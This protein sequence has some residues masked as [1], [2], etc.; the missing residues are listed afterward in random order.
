MDTGL[1]LSLFFNPIFK[2]IF[3]DLSLQKAKFFFSFTS[4]TNFF[5]LLSFSSR[6]DKNI[7]L[8]Y[9]NSYVLW[10]VPC[11]IIVSWS[12]NK[13]NIYFQISGK[14]MGLNIFEILLCHHMVKTDQRNRSYWPKLRGFKKLIMK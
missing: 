6:T 7:Q 5:T 10:V 14:P 2:H 9:R 1:Y 12:S 8:Y 11:C 13:P 3:C 4:S